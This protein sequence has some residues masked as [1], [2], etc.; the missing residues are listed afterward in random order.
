MGTIIKDYVKDK[1][2]SLACLEYKKFHANLCP[3]TDN[4]L[5][6]K[7]PVIRSFAKELLSEY[8]ISYLY[9]KIDDEYYEEIMLKGIIIGFEKDIDKVKEYISNFV[10]KIDNWAIC[11]TFCAG[12][13]IT[14]KY[15]PIM[16]EFILDYRKSSNEFELRFMLVMILDYYILDEYLEDNFKI[17]DSIRVDSYYV[18]MALA[19]ALSVSFIKFYDKTLKYFVNS[20]LN[21]FVYNKTISKVC[22]SYR[23]SDKHKKKLKSL[24]R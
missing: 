14:K 19:W 16:R 20:N 13:K 17:F 8:S 1:L 6:V 23:V 18:N 10:L 7:V 2:R 21:D 9:E 3:G 11:D 15:L 24:R 12:L 22:D 5:G 4:I